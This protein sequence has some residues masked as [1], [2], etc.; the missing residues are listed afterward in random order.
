MLKSDNPLA[1]CHRPVQHLSSRN[2]DHARPTYI[3]QQLRLDRDNPPSG[4]DKDTF[5]HGSA[6]QY[7][8]FSDHIPWILVYLIGTFNQH[9]H[10][11]LRALHPNTP[12]ATARV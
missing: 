5:D 3:V 7:L 6:L 12:R 4:N 8:Q 1:A 9:Q 10:G 2:L 11:E